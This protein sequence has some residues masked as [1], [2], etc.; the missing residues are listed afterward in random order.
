MY[1]ILANHNQF[2][3]VPDVSY[4]ADFFGGNNAWDVAGVPGYPAAPH[5]DPATGLGSPDAAHLIR[6]LT[7]G[8]A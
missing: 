1:Q 7:L 4:D 5:W 3:G 8:L 2:R 6:L